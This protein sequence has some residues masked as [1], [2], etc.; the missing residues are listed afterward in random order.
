MARKK[1][2][3]RVLV[4]LKCTESGR[5]NYITSKNKVNT[6]E[7]LELMKYSPTLRRTTLHKE[8]NKLD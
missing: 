7:K 3:K 8:T 5:V 4:G 6:V 1:K 2:G